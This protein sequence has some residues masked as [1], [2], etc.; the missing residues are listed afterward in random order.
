MEYPLYGKWQYRAQRFFK[1]LFIVVATSPLLAY[2]CLLIVRIFLWLA[3]IMLRVT[4][5]YS[6]I[7]FLHMLIL[8]LVVECCIFFVKYPF[9]PY[10]WI[11]DDGLY[12]AKGARRVLVPWYGIN[13]IK[14][15]IDENNALHIVLTF[16]EDDILLEKIWGDGW[17]SSSTFFADYFF[18][19]SIDV[20]SED[21]GSD[22]CECE[23]LEAHRRLGMMPTDVTIPDIFSIPLSDIYDR[24]ITAWNVHRK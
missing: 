7:T 6:S 8:V 17:H 18:Y 3:G 14:L 22:D 4:H 23:S 9:G 1:K 11:A 13:N 10:L 15:S 19:S 2:P 24:M 16:G 21:P 5:L 20:C 12:V